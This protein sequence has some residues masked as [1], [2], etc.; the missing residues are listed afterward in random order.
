MQERYSSAD[1]FQGSRIHHHF[2][3]AANGFEI[4]IISADKVASNVSISKTQALLTLLTLCQ[5]CLL[6]AFM[7][8]IGLLGMLH[9]YLSNA[10]K[11]MSNS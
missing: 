5:G 7:M 2:I 11:Y 4:R 1:S 10:M 3:N 9:K 6:L 8:T